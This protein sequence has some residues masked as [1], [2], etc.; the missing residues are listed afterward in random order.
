ML[1]T[2]GTIGLVTPIVMFG[3]MLLAIVS[4]KQFNWTDNALSDLGIQTGI[5]PILFNGSLIASGLL[6]IVFALGLSKSVGKNLMGKIGS[7]SFIIASVFL[8]AIG[9]LNESFSPIHNVVAVTFFI[10][11]FI[12]L[13]FL[14]VSFWQSGKRK[15][16][17]FTLISILSGSVMWILQFTLHYVQGIA[18]PEAVS[19]FLG[20]TWILV[21]GYFL[22]CESTKK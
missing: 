15:L 22:L 14:S 9:I 2:A 20:A 17:L 5:T 16:S 8:M 3:C 7:G 4:W 21:L 10:F 11:L 1:K 19:G 12:S 18:I 6:F 13:M